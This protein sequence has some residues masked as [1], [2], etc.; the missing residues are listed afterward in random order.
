MAAALGAAGLVVTGLAISSGLGSGPAVDT[1]GSEPSVVASPSAETA[2]PAATPARRPA[3]SA[4]VGRANASLSGA[5]AEV[6]PPVRIRMGSVDIDAVVRPVGIAGDG[7]MQLP[8]DPRVMG[9]YRFGP[10]PSPGTPGSAVIAGHLDAE[11]FGLGPLVRLR[12]VAVGDRLDVVLAD[13]TTEPFV[14]RSVQRFDRQGLPPELFARSG[15]SRLRVIT[16]GGEY[17]PKAGGYQQNLVVTA[18]PG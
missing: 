1:A 4:R 10:A 17:L 14:V 13:G 2:T 3:S 5:A 6:T 16:C 18:V 11:G 15:P 7:Q 9:W 12:E 8:P